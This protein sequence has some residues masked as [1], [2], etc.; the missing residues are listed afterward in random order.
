MRVEGGLWGGSMG[1]YLSLRSSVWTFW[2][3]KNNHRQE[4]HMQWG[5]QAC[6]KIVDLVD[7]V[8]N[9]RGELSD[10]P[11]CLLRTQ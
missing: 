4:A 7:S 9:S 8:H 1:A 3:L 2:G 5:R 6:K 10:S 11:R